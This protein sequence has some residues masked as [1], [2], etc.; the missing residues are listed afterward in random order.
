MGATG[1]LSKKTG[2]Q[3]GHVLGVTHHVAKHDIVGQLESSRYAGF[4]FMLFLSHLDDIICE[5]KQRPQ[6][7]VIGKGERPNPFNG[8]HADVFSETTI[9]HQIQGTVGKQ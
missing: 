4:F 2:H 9:A 1:L 5:A 7:V 8:K 6:I 3:I